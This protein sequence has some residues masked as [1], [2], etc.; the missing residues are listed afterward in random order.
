MGAEVALEAAVL[1]LEVEHQAG[2]VD[3]RLDLAAVADDARVGAELRELGL[4]ERGDEAVVEAAER[5]VDAGPLVVDDL[6]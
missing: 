2:V 6:P 4:R 3:D 1:L 5:L